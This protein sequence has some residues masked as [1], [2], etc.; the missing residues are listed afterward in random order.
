MAGSRL[1]LRPVLAV[2]L[3]VSLGIPAWAQLGRVSGTVR[4]VDGRPLKGATVVAENPD[5]SPGSFTAITNEKGQFSMIGL[6]SGAWSFTASSPG[7]AAASGRARVQTIGSNQ[8][9]EF[10]LQRSTVFGGGGVLAGVNVKELQGQITAADGLVAAGRYDEALAGY[11]D[12]LARAPALTMINLQI[13]RILQL[14]HDV[15]G[16][17]AAYRDWLAHDAG[18]ERAIVALGLALLEAGDVAQA[19]ATLAPVAQSSSASAAVLFGYAEVKLAQGLDDDA[20]RFYERAAAADATWVKPL[21]KR[22]LV[23]LNKGDRDGA[24]K[25]LDRVVALAP[26]SEEASQ[27]RTLLDQLR[28]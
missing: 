21:L 10:R 28:R 22:G 20:A 3:V 7:F 13:G 11:R 5:L 17:V 24:A 15:A 26:A 25:Y 18:N 23:A 1:F 27:A 4:D 9:L 14:K 19:E 6:R 16:A 12:V 8:P 2:M